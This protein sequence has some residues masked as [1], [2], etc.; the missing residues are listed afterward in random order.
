MSERM[1]EEEMM[2]EFLKEGVSPIT[3]E[4]TIL[5]GDSAMGSKFEDY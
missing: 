3:L 4:D 1:K 5:F 2:K